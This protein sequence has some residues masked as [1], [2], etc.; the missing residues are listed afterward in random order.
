MS[1]AL[2]ASLGGFMNVAGAFAASHIASETFDR[3]RR[4]SHQARLLRLYEADQDTAQKVQAERR[5]A[6]AR[7]RRRKAALAHGV[8]EAGSSSEEE[9]EPEDGVDGFDDGR[10]ACARVAVAC[11]RV[12]RSPW[13][14][15]LPVLRG[16]LLVMLT[17][18]WRCC[19]A[20]LR[21]LCWG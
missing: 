2:G 18:C 7:A 8:M 19:G 15:T 21:A 10:C 13:P 16:R 12:R 1:I 3:K 14:L 6:R 5:A 4:E 9:S 11:R 20:G 17:R